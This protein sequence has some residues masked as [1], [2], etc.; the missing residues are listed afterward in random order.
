[1]EKDN[2]LLYACYI[3]DIELIKERL[4]NVKTSQL[5]KSTRETGTP[6]H[7]AAIN[8]NYEAVDLLLEAGSYI[9]AGNF[10]KNSPL[11]NC[12]E[13]NKLHM[14]RYLI[15]KGANV[16][17]KGC[18]NRH[19]LSQLILYA[20]DTEFAKYLL[21][22]GCDINQKSIDKGTLLGDAASSDNQ[23]AIDFLLKNGIDKNYFNSALCWAII[24]KSVDAVRL[25]LNNGGNFDEMYA[26][27]KGIEKGLYHIVARGSLHTNM[28]KLLLEKGIDFT[29][30]PTR[31]VVVGLDK[32]K[33]SP[34]DYIK[35]EL[36]LFP[37]ATFL[38]KHIEIIENYKFI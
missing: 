7:I 28:L 26:Q 13:N 8:G 24:H 3:N 25:L 20:W 1:M 31:A 14:A 18:Q 11:L 2:S 6:L 4:N 12:I 33:L 37:E 22:K 30:I 29:E 34:I 10:L 35:E 27:C 32:T 38:Q 17:K 9:E 16:N 5:K 15:E 36:R 19:A 21:E 23:K